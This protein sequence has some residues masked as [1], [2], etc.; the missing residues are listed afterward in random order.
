[1]VEIY[2]KRV[3]LEGLNEP[4]IVT[5]KY[6]PTLSKISFLEE[7]AVDVLENEHMGD[8]AVLLPS[9]RTVTTFKRILTQKVLKACRMPHVMT[10]GAFM[11]G[12][13]EFQAADN[14]EI[15][16]RLYQVQ[17]NSNKAIKDFRLFLN[18]G[19]VAIADFHQ[20]DHHM[21]DANQ[22]FKNLRDIKEIEEWSFDITHELTEAQTAFMKQWDRLPHLYKDLHQ[23]LQKDGMTTKAKLSWNVA[24]KG[25]VQKYKTV[26]AA[27]LAA[28]TPSEKLYLT[29]W[30]EAGKLIYLPDADVSYVND[31]QIEAG[32]FMRYLRELPCKIPNKIAQSP[33]DLEIIG[34]SSVMSS[35]QLIRQIVLELS[36]DEK[37]KTVIVL[38][39][40]KTLPVLL[41]SLPN[42]D[43]GYNV[44]MGL[45][46][47]ETPV[48]PFL[49]L[50]HTMTARLDKG[51]RFEELVSLSS[52]QVILEYTKKT[53]SF[54]SDATNALHKIAKRNSA[55][56]STTTVKEISDGT[57]YSLLKELE[58]L[59]THGAKEFLRELDHFTKKIEVNLKESNSPWIKAGWNS[60]RKVVSIMLRLQSDLNP[61]S[62]ASD[63]RALMH[64]LLVSEKIHLIGE[65]ARGLQIMGLTETRALDYDRV[66]IM[67]CNEGILPKNKMIDSY[68]PADLMH[69]L[70]M[71]G[72]H[73]REAAY[74]YSVYRLLNRSIKVQLLYRTSGENSEEMSRYLLQFLHSYKPLK[75][76]LTTS[77]FSMP[78]PKSRP[79]I[80]AIKLTDKMRDRIDIWAKEGISPSALNKLL[81]C[82]RNFIYRYLLRLL[83]PN[84]LEEN[85]DSSTLG[86]IVHHVFEHGLADALKQTLQPH[87]IKSILQNLD[88]FLD[89]AV[90]YYYKHGVSDSGEN[91]LLIRSA[92]STIKKMLNQELLEL[93][94]GKG[95]LM[96]ITALEESLE[97]T[98]T[99]SDGGKV[100]FFGYADRLEDISG[101]T[102]VVDYKTGITTQTD[103]NLKDDWNIEGGKLDKGNAS[104]ALQL[105]VYCCILLK[106]KTLL[107]V[108]ASIRS[109]RNA[110]SGLLNLKIGK[111]KDINRQ[112]IDMLID[113]ISNKLSD[114]KEK[115]REIS[116]NE[117][118]HYCDYCVVLDPPIISY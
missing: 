13:G 88:N 72:R 42:N 78:I 10:L 91:L 12:D 38:P 86:S 27:G 18:W 82:K 41:Q 29:K 26:Y 69:S 44:T 28:I 98:Y 36:E 67:D 22:V 113:W 100:K 50:I 53:T 21:K 109:G 83:E 115:G 118:S 112:D 110:H 35:C 51:W 80:P 57:F 17:V 108:R 8:C 52:Q 61:C 4:F 71:P 74:A 2:S 40:A 95:E 81:S 63:V 111:R 25:D 45:N 31:A 33:P 46:L 32:Y 68:L 56:V 15:L 75:G 104:K 73:E 59:K 85:I 47:S 76:S 16:A 37:N 99:L 65:P 11:E 23:R 66:I 94:K 20:I 77:T 9:F 3:Y 43:V 70:N 19:S 92:K 64:Q 60:V 106:D 116:H 24:K 107:E 49:N 105:L 55:W 30:H 5:Q 89:N 84:E 87:H 1:L 90:E 39:D 103:L 79:E 117:D 34:C 14:L 96:T 102:R 97:A 54:T 48:S 58:P 62:N 101:V 6:S 114:F 93:N 7:L